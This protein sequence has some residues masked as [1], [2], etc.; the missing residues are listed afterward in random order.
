MLYAR[1]AILAAFSLGKE[2]VDVN[3]KDQSRC[4]P[5]YKACADGHTATAV[6]LIERGADVNEKE[7]RVGWTPLFYACY[8]DHTATAVALIERVN[9]F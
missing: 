5:L 1:V 7:H 3:E 4:I 9:N 8:S 2:E 6:A